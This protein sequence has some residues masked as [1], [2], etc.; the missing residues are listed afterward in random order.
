MTPTPSQLQAAILRLLLI[1]ADKGN[2]QRHAT[3]AWEA[4]EALRPDL[5]LMDPCEA[6][7]MIKEENSPT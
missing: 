3:L 2:R 7:E 6:I 4:L 5:S 1:Q